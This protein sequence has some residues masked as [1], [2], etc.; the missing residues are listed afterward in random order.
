MSPLEMRS[1]SLGMQRSLTPS[2]NGYCVSL[3]D[4]VV[5][6]IVLGLNVSLC[7]WRAVPSASTVL[8]TA[9]LSFVGVGRWG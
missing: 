5:V 9:L 2:L 7:G 4:G 1:G 8:A 6:E 3:Y